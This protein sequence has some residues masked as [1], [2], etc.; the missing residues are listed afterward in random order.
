MTHYETFKIEEVRE[1]AKLIERGNELFAKEQVLMTC[2][3]CLMYVFNNV[4]EALTFIIYRVKEI[5]TDFN[6][7]FKEAR[8]FNIGSPDIGINIYTSEESY[9]IKTLNSYRYKQDE[10]KAKKE[11][12]EINFLLDNNHVR[13]I[14]NLKSKA[15]LLKLEFNH[16]NFSNDDEP[17]IHMLNR[18]FGHGGWLR[19]W[20][21][22][23]PLNKISVEVTLNVLLADEYTIINVPSDKP[24][25]AAKKL[26]KNLKM[27]EEKQ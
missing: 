18:Y 14:D 12:E 10:E 20:F 13:F 1:R 23:K 4:C 7:K 24:I 8:I 3:D 22:T 6:I 2:S 16:F 17:I 5:E 25:K 27:I 26:N 21:T 9:T 15:E 11:Q 19:Y